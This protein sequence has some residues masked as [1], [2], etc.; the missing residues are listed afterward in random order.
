MTHPA[1]AIKHE[2][3]QLA[4]LQIQTL[5]QQSSLTSSELLDYH[6]RFEKITVLYQEMDRISRTRV[7]TQL[8]SVLES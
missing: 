3:H 4:D 6:G 2:V 5:R 8:R 7:G 1:S